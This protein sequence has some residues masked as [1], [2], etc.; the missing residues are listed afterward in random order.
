MPDN[1]CAGFYECARRKGF[2]DP[3]ANESLFLMKGRVDVLED[4]LL[5]KEAIIADYLKKDMDRVLLS[6]SESSKLE[7]VLSKINEIKRQPTELVLETSA[8][9]QE[10]REY[11]ASLVK[12]ISTLGS[13]LAK[14]DAFSNDLIVSEAN[15]KSEAKEKID[16]LE[17]EVF[18]Y[19]RFVDRLNDL[20]PEKT[21]KLS[22]LSVLL[23]E[24]HYQ[25]S[26]GYQY[27]ND[28]IKEVLNG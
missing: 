6:E 15:A 5:E 8:S 1:C 10:L 12:Q 18:S 20:I 2:V 28:L 16:K 13:K 4:M 27:G 23:A 26:N 24:P 25:D 14:L 9:E 11:N 22:V 17:L 19:K 3:D 7:S 21:Q